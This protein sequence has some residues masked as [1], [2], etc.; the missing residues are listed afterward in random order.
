MVL[1]SV[2][3]MTVT[4]VTI[5]SVSMSWEMVVEVEGVWALVRVCAS[6]SNIAFRSAAEIDMVLVVDI[7][8][9]PGGVDGGVMSLPSCWRSVIWLSH[10]YDALLNSL[11]DCQPLWSTGVGCEANGTWQWGV[12][13]GSC[14][15]YFHGCVVVAVCHRCGFTDPNMRQVLT[16]HRAGAGRLGQVLIGMGM[17]SALGW[18]ATWVW[19]DCVV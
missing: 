19:M 2:R 12:F 4:L 10:V 9:C 14:C 7:D 3:P 17:V 15:T 16:V 11:S 1:R 8:V 18:S 13:D 5:D 6:P